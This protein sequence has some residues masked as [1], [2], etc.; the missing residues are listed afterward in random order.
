MNVISKIK[1]NLLW[2][3]LSFLPKNQNKA[4]CQSFYGK[5]YSDSPKAVADELL[6]RGWKVYWVVKGEK[7]AAS[8]PDRAIPL[9]LD[10]AR[11]IYH[12]CTAG[13]WVDCCRKWAYTQKRGATCYVQ[14]WHGFPLKRIEKDAAAALPQDYQQAAQKDSQMCDLFL[15]NSRFL[16]EIY[17]KAFWYDGEVLECGFPRNDVLLKENPGLAGKVRAALGLPEGKRLL[18]YA[19]TFRKGMGLS[20]YNMDYDRCVQAL[21]K[22]FG[23]EWLILARLHPNIAEKAEKLIRDSRC[24]VNASDYPDI[25]EL[26]LAADA[27]ITDYSSTMFDFM[28]TGKPCLLFVNDLEDYRNDR[29]FYFEL[30]NLPFSLAKDNDELEAALLEFDEERQRRRIKD[31]EKE[32]GFCESG[33]AARQTADWLE[34]RRECR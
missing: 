32:Y 26:Y 11:A 16:T 10:S 12:L 33:A 30:E 20:A 7:E 25:Q 34:K 22:R 8:L 23:G 19:P 6:S 3:A 13:V 4:V 17:H 27:M 14:T 18:L 29:N 1:R 5:G 9:K 15:S 21:K 2:Q 28:N 24:L 31:F